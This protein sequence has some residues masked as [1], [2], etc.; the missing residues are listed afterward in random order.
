MLDSR[1]GAANQVIL[2]EQ[3]MGPISVST[4]FHALVMR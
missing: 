3:T 4:L 2:F 1:P